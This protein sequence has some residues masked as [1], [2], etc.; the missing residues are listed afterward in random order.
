[1]TIAERS[2]SKACDALSTAFSLYDMDLTPRPH[3]FELKYEN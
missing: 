3:S 2:E 1:M